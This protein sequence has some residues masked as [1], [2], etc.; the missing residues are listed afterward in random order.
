MLFYSIE[1]WCY[2]VALLLIYFLSP[3]RIKKIVLLSFNLFFY[4]SFGIKPAILILLISIVIHFIALGFRHRK[5][6]I[7][8]II[9]LIISI[10]TL[11]VLKYSG[12]IVGSVSVLTGGTVVSESRIIT[13]LVLPVGLSFYTFQAMGYLLDVYQGK[14]EAERNLFKTLAFLTFFPTIISG[15]ILRYNDIKP[16]FDAPIAF[17]YKSFRD[18]ILM[19]G[20]GLFQKMVI[21][22]RIG[23]VVDQAY[24]NHMAYKGFFVVLIA[25]YYALQIYFDF[26]GYSYMA[27][28][29]SRMIGIEIKDNFN[30]PYFS[31]SIAEFWRRWHISL[32]S[33]LRDYLYIPLGGNRKGKVRKFLNIMIVFLVSGIW[34]GAD[35]SFVLWGGMHGALQ[36]I[37]ALVMKPKKFIIEKLKIDT[38]RTATKCVCIVWNFILISYAWIFFRAD[39]IKQA[40]QFIKNTFKE[41]NLWIFFDGSIYTLGL[42]QKE[43]H[44]LMLSLLIMLVLDVLKYKGQD[45]IVMINRQQMVIRWLIYLVVIFSV[46]IYGIYGTSYNASNFIYMSF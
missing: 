13:K 8:L 19:F 9:S 34:H 35:W 38:E 1:F 7:L 4:A 5:R 33:W 45:I 23:I 20:V 15:P 11:V 10:G 27:I 28:G 44:V 46:L 6:T 18:G 42:D 25:A 37:Q 26:A 29:I 24:D 30:T 40:L 36:I 41:F 21:A 43:M 32:S 12:F 14:Y 17:N 39:N 16:Q 3:L 31:M 2:F 22:D